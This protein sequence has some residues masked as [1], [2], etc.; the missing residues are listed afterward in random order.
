MKEIWGKF[1]IK[2]ALEF[3]NMNCEIK[4][5]EENEEDKSRTE[6]CSKVGYKDVED[7]CV[8]EEEFE[9]LKRR[10]MA[11]FT[12]KD[13]LWALFWWYKWKFKSQKRLEMNNRY[14]LF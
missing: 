7:I 12:F 11:S 1:M 2:P 14:K 4:V 5:M 3:R 13:T 9:K 6:L 8:K 10:R